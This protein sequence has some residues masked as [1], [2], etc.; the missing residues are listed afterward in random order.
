MS[1]SNNNYPR[2]RIRSHLPGGT[3]ACVV[4]SRLSEIPGVSVLLLCKGTVE[5]T[6]FYRIPLIVSLLEAKAI[7]AS[8]VFSEPVKECDGKQPKVFTS[9]ALG[10]A[11]RMNGLMLTRGS[12][13]CFNEWAE[14]D[15]PDWSWDRVEAY[16]KKFENAHCYPDAAHRGH[17]G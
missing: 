2:W 12:P 3:A 16:F 5:D 7:Q 8:T 17:R 1:T 15:N 11:T 14:M 10:G 13:G 6:Y 4:A 9:N